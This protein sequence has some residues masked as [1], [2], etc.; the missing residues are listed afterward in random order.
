MTQIT[1][2][3]LLLKVFEM[4]KM[5]LWY[6]NGKIEEKMVDNIGIRCISCGGKNGLDVKNSNLQRHGY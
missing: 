5:R 4:F 1:L 3:L 6:G 2:I